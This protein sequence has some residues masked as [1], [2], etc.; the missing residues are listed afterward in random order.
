VIPK[1]IVTDIEGTT[2]SIAFVHEVLFPYARARLAQFVADH[3]EQVAPVLAAV[4]EEA[5]QADLDIDGCVALLLEW[6]DADRKIG[7]L[8][9][10]QGMIWA[11]G[12]AAGALHGHIYDDAVAALRRWHEAG[13]ALYVYSSGSVAAQR[14]LFG[15]TAQGDL[16]GLFSGHFDTA[17]GGKKEAASY[18]TIAEAIGLPANEVLFLSDV[19]DE[20][21]AAQSAGFEVI[22]LA[23]ED[24]VESPFPTVASFD[25]IMLPL[26]EAHRCP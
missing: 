11:E 9:T 1:A 23:R 12:Y 16:T 25:Q 18:R 26:E 6:H 20:L 13:I 5:G 10:L 21:A 8:K 15:H 17:I 4:R 19:V 7:P 3:P 2:S 14:L 22:L 24:A